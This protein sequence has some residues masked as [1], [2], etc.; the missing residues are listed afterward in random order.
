MQTHEKRVPFYKFTCKYKTHEISKDSLDLESF[1]DIFFANLIKVSV[2][3]MAVHTSV[4]NVLVCHTYN[5]DYQNLETW[6]LQ[7][8]SLN[9]NKAVASQRAQL[10]LNASSVAHGKHFAATS[11]RLEAERLI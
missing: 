8:I 6:L 5:Y 4:Y 11:S 1:L 2:L 10:H 7:F 9:L 3:P